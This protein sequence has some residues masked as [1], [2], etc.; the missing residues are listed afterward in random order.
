MQN[1]RFFNDVFP[2]V[3]FLY[4]ARPRW[5][6]GPDCTVRVRARARR[7]D[8]SEVIT[9]VRGGKICLNSQR[10]QGGKV[11]EVLEKRW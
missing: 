11:F 5:S 3:Q 2:T 10:A 4:S 8:L 9:G 1:R 7:V 6:D